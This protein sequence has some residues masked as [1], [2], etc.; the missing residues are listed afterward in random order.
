MKSPLTWTG[1]V[2][3]GAAVAGATAASLWPSAPVQEERAQACAQAAPRLYDQLE[4]WASP[5]SEIALAEPSLSYE[6]E[7]DTPYAAL[8]VH[9]PASVQPARAIALLD[10]GWTTDESTH[11]GSRD[12]GRWEVST[13]MT[14]MDDGTPATQVLFVNMK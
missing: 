9:L 6:C 1:L 5:L 7:W 10:A 14:T 4:E 11:S 2:V 8:T 12:D 3:A 13:S